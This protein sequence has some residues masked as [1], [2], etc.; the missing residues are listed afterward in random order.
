MY[1]AISPLQHRGAEIDIAEHT[2]ARIGIGVVGSSAEQRRGHGPELLYS[3]NAKPLLAFE[4]VEEG[5][6]GH[7][8]RSTDIVH[9][10]CRVTLRANDI[11]GG[12]EQPGPR[13]GAVVGSAHY[14]N[15]N[16]LVL[17]LSQNHLAVKSVS[18]GAMN[19]DLA[20]PQRACAYA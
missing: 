20:H 14:I 13:F 3:C 16:W 12:I 17:K 1:C 15:T 2:V 8:R 9:R 7:A 4:M 5:A 6:L 19:S 10:G 18:W 11:A